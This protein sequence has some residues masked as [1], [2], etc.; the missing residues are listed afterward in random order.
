[1]TPFTEAQLVAM[2]DDLESDRI[3]RKETWAGDAPEKSR[4]AVCAFVIAATGDPPTL[5]ALRAHLMAQGMARYKLPSRLEIIDV[6]PRNPA[7][8]VLKFELRARFKR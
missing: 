4:E 8:K 5:E 6:L 7:G 3:E 2:L 1:M